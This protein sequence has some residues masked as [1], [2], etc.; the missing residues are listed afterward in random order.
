VLKAD[1]DNAQAHETM[2]YLAY[3]DGDF[4]GASKWYEQAVKLNSQSFLANYYFAMM[5][6]RDGDS[7]NKPEVES[8]LR[9]AIKLNPYFA[10]AYDQLAGL[11]AMRHENL[12][13]AHML[14]LQAIELDPGNI[15][16]RMNA[17]MVLMTMDRYE[18]AATVLRNSE[19]ITTTATEAGLLQSRLKEIERMQAVG[20]HPNSTITVPPTGQAD[21]ETVNTVVDIIPK[22]P[23]EPLTGPKHTVVGVIHAVQCSYPAVIEFQ[24][25]G[26]KKPVSVY[27][28]NYMKIDLTVLGFTPSG[29]M[30]PCKDFEGMKARVQYAESSDKTV[31]GQ[32]IAVELRK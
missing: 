5:A 20:A 21:T 28:N 17:A 8:S 11:L 3:R 4:G 29:D 14:N 18:D 25:D 16:Y 26:G 12:D 32:V 19:K 9:A 27:S 22:H 23:T 24:I 2:G 6:M 7:S 10:P 30:N 1:P 13:E 31:D 15:A